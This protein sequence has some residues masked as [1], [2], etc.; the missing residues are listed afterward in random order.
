MD[1]NKNQ[2]KGSSE[3]SR[4]ATIGSNLQYDTC[5]KLIFNADLV[6][7]DSAGEILIREPVK[8]ISHLFEG[9]CEHHEAIN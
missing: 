9:S 5:K 1:A 2:S 8:N 3:N 7:K 4:L 6:V